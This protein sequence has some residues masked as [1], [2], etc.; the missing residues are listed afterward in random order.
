[1]YFVCTAPWEQHDMQDW[2]YQRVDSQATLDAAVKELATHNPGKAIYIFKL[3]KYAHAK[4]DIKITNY[5]INEKGE[6]LPE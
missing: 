5:V 2:D 4:F 1:M 3:E 6:V